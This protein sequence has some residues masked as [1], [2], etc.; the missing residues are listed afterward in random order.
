[1]KILWAGPY[2]SEY[3]FTVKR[4]ANIASTVWSHGFV[5]GLKSNGVEVEVITLCPEQA[6][7]KGH[8]LWQNTDSRLFDQDVPVAAIPYLN[9]FGLREY[10]QRFFFARKV[11]EVLRHGQ[12]DAFVCYDVM[13]PYHV[14]GMK[15]AKQFGVKICPIILG[16]GYDVLAEGLDKMSRQARHADG[17]VFLSQWCADRFPA[18]GRRLLQMEGGV[19]EWLGREPVRK[20]HGEPFFVTYAGG[21]AVHKGRGLVEMVRGCTR[22]DVRFIICGK[23]NVPLVKAA[24]GEDPRVELRGMVSNAELREIYSNTDV[25][26]N[27]R[28]TSCGNNFADFPSKILAYL[29]F[30]RPIVSNW[31]DSFPEEYRDILCVAEDD[32]G[33]SM[34]KKLDEV[35]AWTLEQRRARYD[36]LYKVYDEA[37]SWQCQAKRFIDFIDEL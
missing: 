10:W 18:N 33:A 15:V 27:C 6:W 31:I 16:S 20:R 37:K 35:L 26:V 25:F 30:G 2:F 19:S 7:P 1:M 17:V 4:A 14:A 34:A 8:V 11:E 3:A 32:T 22:Q 13:H 24:L 23:W 5:R 29:A 36:A 9:V 28:D 21:I 12:F